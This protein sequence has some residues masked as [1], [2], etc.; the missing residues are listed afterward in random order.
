[1]KPGKIIRAWKDHGGGNIYIDGSPKAWELI[2]SDVEWVYIIR[3]SK[4][5]NVKQTPQSSL[6]TGEPMIEVFDWKKYRFGN[7][8]PDKISPKPI[9]RV[10]LSKARD[11]KATARS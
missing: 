10:K 7:A 5:D 2:H 3:S 8:D 9:L 4:P 1:M 11:A 6:F